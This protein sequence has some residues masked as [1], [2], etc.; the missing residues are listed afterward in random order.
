MR[1]AARTRSD[2]TRPQGSH[3][4]V[5]VASVGIRELKA[6]LSAYVE[7]ARAGETV[8]VT[9]RGRPVAQLAPLAGESVLERLI[10]DGVASRPAARRRLPP[11]VHGKGI[12]SDLVAEQ[13]R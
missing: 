6:Q 1:E 2:Y 10:A 8:V 9:D 12:V 7:R 5:V 3:L 13:R 11:L 4:G